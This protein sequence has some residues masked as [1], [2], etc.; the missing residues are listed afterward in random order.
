M[1]S[2]G[3]F[4]KA[5]STQWRS[6]DPSRVT[7]HRSV[8]PHPPRQPRISPLPTSRSCSTPFPAGG[9]VPPHLRPQ[10]CLQTPTT[11]PPRVNLLFH[12]RASNE[13]LLQTVHLMSRPAFVRPD[14]SRRGFCP[15]PARG[16][17]QKTAR[18]TEVLPPVQRRLRL[19][20]VPASLFVQVSQSVSTL[21]CR[22]HPP[23]PPSVSPEAACTIW[24]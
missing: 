11:N 1:R 22:V 10:T 13:N 21:C 12:V 18:E 15:L 19:C 5:A 20:Q 16:C 24:V 6:M 17:R 14:A 2:V 7:T 4:E 3:S 8:P 9:A 23:A